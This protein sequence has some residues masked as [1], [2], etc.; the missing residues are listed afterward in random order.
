MGDAEDREGEAVMPPVISGAFVL[1]IAWCC[2]LSILG[3]SEIFE[4]FLMLHC[5][6]E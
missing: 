2:Y 5:A 1:C 4:M 3:R 6:S